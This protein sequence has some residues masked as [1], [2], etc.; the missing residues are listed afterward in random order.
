MYD[1][2]IGPSSSNTIAEAQAPANTAAVG[3]AAAGATSAASSSILAP[4]GLALGVHNGGGGPATFFERIT[5]DIEI[6]RVALL[7]TGCV[8]G[9]SRV[10]NTARRGVGKARS[11]SND[12]P[13]RQTMDP[14][15]TQ[16]NH[17]HAHAGIRNTV[18]EY[19]SSF[20]AYDWLWR[21]DKDLFY[22]V[23]RFFNSTSPLTRHTTRS[24]LLLNS[25]PPVTRAPLMPSQGF[26]TTGPSVDAYKERLE[27][28]DTVRIC[29][30]DMC[31][32]VVGLC[33][34]ITHTDTTRPGTRAGGSGDRGHHPSARHRRPALEHLQSQ[35]LAQGVFAI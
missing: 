2:N 31:M 29:P 9:A 26:V 21:D 25:L 10:C 17:T 1:W 15:L 11:G 35:G 33:V 27:A 8:Q 13:T 16:S 3:A 5:R 23:R 18:Q 28:F 14:S 12:G 4:D 6:V 30:K 24:I 7:L 22:Q 34:S 19:L 20:G 32:R